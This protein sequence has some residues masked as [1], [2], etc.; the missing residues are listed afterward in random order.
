MNTPTLPTHDQHNLRPAILVV[1]DDF[2]MRVILAYALKDAY[3]VET[4]ATPEEA[5]E[6]VATHSFDALVL[7]INLRN[8]LDGV[9]LL[10][11]IRERSAYRRVPAVACTV[12][13]RVVDRE[14]FLEAGFEGYVN[15]PFS[16][17]G[18]HDVVARV[19]EGERQVVVTTTL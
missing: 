17:E 15:K 18:L 4:A 12:Y 16:M 5:L 14:W 7:D 2:S 10:E 6:K 3:I 11:R 1:D 8:A 9:A 13:Y 19:L